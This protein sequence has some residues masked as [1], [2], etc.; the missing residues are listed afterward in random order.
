[1]LNRSGNQEYVLA[2]FDGLLEP[3]FPPFYPLFYGL[4]GYP[5]HWE[6]IL[7]GCRVL[8]LPADKSFPAAGRGKGRTLDYMGALRFVKGCAV[9]HRETD[10]RLP[11]SA[12]DLVR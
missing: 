12:K 3:L 11:A 7:R 2:E 6:G 4:W 1:M 10:P 9:A 8:P 5:Y